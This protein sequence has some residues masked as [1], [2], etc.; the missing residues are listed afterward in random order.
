MLVSLIRTLHLNTIFY[1]NIINAEE[2]MRFITNITQN[3]TYFWEISRDYRKES[4]AVMNILKVEMS[5]YHQ[6]IQSESE[7]FSQISRCLFHMAV[8]SCMFI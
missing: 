6:N 5:T 3:S 4:T 7:H 8:S 1:K 2:A